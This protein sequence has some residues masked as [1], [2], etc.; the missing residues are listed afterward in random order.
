MA[1]GGQLGKKGCFRLG[2]ALVDV[3]T[4][5]PAKFTIMGL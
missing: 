3:G 5:C 2:L 4:M 1:D